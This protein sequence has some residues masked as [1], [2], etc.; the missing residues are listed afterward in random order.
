MSLNSGFSLSGQPPVSTDSPAPY[1]ASA[2]LLCILMFSSCPCR[3]PASQNFH[4]EA[5]KLE[6]A[7]AG[8]HPE[9]L[10]S[11]PVSLVLSLHHLCGQCAVICLRGP[12]VVAG[13]YPPCPGLPPGVHQA[14]ASLMD[15]VPSLG[16][17]F[18]QGFE[19][20]PWRGLLTWTDLFVSALGS[21]S[22][23]TATQWP[24]ALDFHPSPGCARAYNLSASVTQTE[25]I[26]SAIYL[27]GLSAAKGD[28]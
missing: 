23:A 12:E 28:Y 2:W 17:Q 15:Q 10:N 13:P 16:C 20:P 8:I 25:L 9:D 22:V 27:P 21:P 3:K 18:C 26:G 1:P 24:I 19:T 4:Y 7:P 11:A 6:A 14:C 5:E